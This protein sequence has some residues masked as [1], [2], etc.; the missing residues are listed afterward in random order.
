LPLGI[1][2]AKTA[3]INGRPWKFSAQYWNYIKSPDPFGP[4]H[5]IRFTVGPVVK[6]PWKGRQ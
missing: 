3:I 1:G 2:I 5:L 6:L 4:E